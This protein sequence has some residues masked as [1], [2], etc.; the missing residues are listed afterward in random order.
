MT[1]MAVPGEGMTIVLTDS[2]LV[3]M[4]VT[5]GGDFGAW[6]EVWDAVEMSET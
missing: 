4:C 3:R 2:G 6:I 5:V 1:E